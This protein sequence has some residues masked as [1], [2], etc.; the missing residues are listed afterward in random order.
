MNAIIGISI[1]TVCVVVI[2]TFVVEERKQNKKMQ[3]WKRQIDDI[4]Q[5]IQDTIEIIQSEKG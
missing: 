5:S 3:Q 4:R 2:V 1:I